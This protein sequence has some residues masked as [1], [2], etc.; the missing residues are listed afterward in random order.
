MAAEQ[1]N[2]SEGSGAKRVDARQAARQKV[3]ASERKQPVA[4]DED[5]DYSEDDAPSSFEDEDTRS[6][7]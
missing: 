4:Y 1:D 5:N 6:V 2:D 7:S 3:F